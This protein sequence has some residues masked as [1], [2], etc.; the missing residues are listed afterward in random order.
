MLLPLGTAF[1]L[2]LISTPVIVRI[3]VA[4][5]VQVSEAFDALQ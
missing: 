3:Y 1:S 2:K 4:I 5:Q